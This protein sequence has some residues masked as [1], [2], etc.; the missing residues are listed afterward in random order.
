MVTTSSTH[1]EPINNAYSHL[2]PPFR[3]A[4]RW[5]SPRNQS[6]QSIPHLAPQDRRSKDLVEKKVI[7]QSRS[8]YPRNPHQGMYEPFH[9]ISGLQQKRRFV[10]QPSW[11]RAMTLLPRL[12][13]VRGGSCFRPPEQP[14]GAQPQATRWSQP[15]CAQKRT[16]NCT[17]QTRTTSSF[18]A[19]GRRNVVA[20]KHSVA[21][22]C[23]PMARG[24]NH[25]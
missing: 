21:R 7:L 23:C 25:S 15:R 17:S 19:I 22:L 6:S 16:G 18:H 10:M 12:H 5:P 8:K 9:I 4:S 11:A 1:Q 3:R 20:D 13:P 2:P 24:R 14:L